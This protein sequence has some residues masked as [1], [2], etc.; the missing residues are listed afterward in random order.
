MDNLFIEPP[1]DT[2][3]YL[4]NKFFISPLTDESSLHLVIVA[5][6]SSVDIVVPFGEWT[7]AEF[8]NG[9]VLIKKGSFIT[10]IFNKDSIVYV[11]Q[12]EGDEVE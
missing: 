6:N 5:N 7:L 4:M 9:Y 1:T 2:K 10:H 11:Q 12:T 8:V 3:V